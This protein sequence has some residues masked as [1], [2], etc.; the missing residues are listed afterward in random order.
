[1]PPK[2]ASKVLAWRPA[3]LYFRTASPISGT[4]IT[5]PSSPTTGSSWS[6]R[7]CAGKKY[8][9][10]SV[11][12]RS[13]SPS[14]VS[15]ECSTKRSRESSE[16]MSS[17]SY[18]INSMSRLDITRERVI[19]IQNSSMEAAPAGPLNR[20]VLFEPVDGPD[21]V[22]FNYQLSEYRDWISSSYLVYTSRRFI[23]RLGVN[24]PAST[25][26]SEDNT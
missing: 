7:R 6:A 26:H 15:R 17:H 25:V 1:M 21:L 2:S 24:S 4:R 11:S 13:S 3:S 10:A 12:L 19:S 5:R 16:S 23:L 8:S 9:T 22:E 20:S 14:I 18:S